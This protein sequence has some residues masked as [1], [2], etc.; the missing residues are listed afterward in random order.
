MKKTLLWFIPMCVIIGVVI[1]VFSHIYESTKQLKSQTETV[2]YPDIDLKI[3]PSVSKAME[4]MA[5]P[6]VS[7]ALSPEDIAQRELALKRVASQF[8]AA[9]TLYKNQCLSCHGHVAQG[10][11]ALASLGS[12]MNVRKNVYTVP[13]LRSSAL[14]QSLEAFFEA[15]S[16]RNSP[17]LPKT[18]LAT[19]KKEVLE[20]Q[21]YLKAL[22]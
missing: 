11:K 3:I 8:P 15:A 17:H 6:G 22:T 4:T 18:L 13:P 14:P 19:D 20:L 1:V 7:K 10:G 12:R 2:L 9:H 21:A 16:K 5:A